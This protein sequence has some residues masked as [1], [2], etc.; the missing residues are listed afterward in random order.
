MIHPSRHK[1]E[2]ANR[3]VRVLQTV[4]IVGVFTLVGSA[5][6]NTAFESQPVEQDSSTSST[7]A[8]PSSDVDGDT[9][10][11]N[12][13]ALVADSPYEE[14]D[15]LAADAEE[16]ISETAAEAPEDEP[17]A[18]DPEDTA[19]VTQVAVGRG[20]SV[21]CASV[22]IGRDA[23]SDGADGLVATQQDLLVAGVDLVE[24]GELNT[25]LGAIEETAP[26]DAAILDAALIRCEELGFQP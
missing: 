6:S 21:V 23:L 14:P 26:I 11:G 7:E 1:S 22:Q 10:A 20:E 16:E 2:A 5:C 13:L 19:D 17:V 15:L 9:A 3:A 18:A 8:S 24:D 4:T 12:E 25:V